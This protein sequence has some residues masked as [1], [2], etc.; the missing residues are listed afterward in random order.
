MQED[1]FVADSMH[2]A[3]PRAAGY[4]R[5][6]LATAHNPLRTILRRPAG[7]PSLQGPQAELRTP[8]RRAARVP[9]LQAR[10]HSNN[11]RHP[12]ARRRARGHRSGLP[13]DGAPRSDRLP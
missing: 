13:Q 8:A 11:S 3:G 10:P 1:L 4:K 12:T 7:R 5:A 6:I 2:V 9:R